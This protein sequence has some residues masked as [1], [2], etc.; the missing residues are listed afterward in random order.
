MRSVAGLQVSLYS[1]YG[2]MSRVAKCREERA[3]TTTQR[4]EFRRER[5]KYYTLMVYEDADA[6][7]LRLFESF[8]ESAPQLVGLS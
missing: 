5:V 7:L 2:V 3:T 6:A 1:R 8:M 4:E